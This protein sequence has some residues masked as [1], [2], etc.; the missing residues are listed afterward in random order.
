LRIN[1]NALYLASKRPDLPL[2]ARI[3]IAIVLGSALSPN[4]LIP[5]LI[6][7]LGYVDDIILIPLRIW[8]ALKLVLE[9]I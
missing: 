3:F 4:D 1:T 2:Y 5:D 6:H 7:V 8:L 9:D